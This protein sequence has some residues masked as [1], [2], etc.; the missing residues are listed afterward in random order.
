M[1]TY[2]T[3]VSF[4]QQGNRVTFSRQRSNS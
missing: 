2:M 1:R 3:W 4:N